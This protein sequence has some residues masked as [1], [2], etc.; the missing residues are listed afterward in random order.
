ME[1]YRH[2]NRFFIIFVLLSLLL[3]LLLLLI[4]KDSLFPRPARPEP[5]YV[6]IRPLPKSELARELDLPVR[7][8]LEK[9]RQTPAKRLG[10][11][12]QVVEKEIAPKGKDDIDLLLPQR[13]SKPAPAVAPQADTR[14]QEKPRENIARQETRDPLEKR[15]TREG[16]RPPAAA[17]PA[18]KPFPDMENLTTISPRALASIESAWRMKYRKDVAQGDT[19]WLNTKHDL[20]NSFMRRFRD[21]IY[22]VWDYPAAALQQMQRGTCL[23]H[24]TINRRGDVEDVQLLESSGYALLDREAIESVWKGATYGPLPKAYPNDNLKIMAFFQYRMGNSFQVRRRAG[25]I[26]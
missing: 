15:L 25:R 8:E 1:L 13:A 7:K 11:A 26:Y 24:I 12:D 4:P 21:N 3:H 9:P 2:Q 14:A 23:L 20:L 10:P 5:V 18:P 16:T 22:L 17:S 6:E 19:V